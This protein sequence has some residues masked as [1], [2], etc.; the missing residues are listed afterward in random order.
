[1]D[2]DP[3]LPQVIVGTCGCLLPT[4]SKPVG[5]R[6]VATPTGD[7]RVA[8]YVCREHDK[9]KAPLEP[10]E[11]PEAPNKRSR[12]PRRVARAPAAS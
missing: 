10:T 4:D 11:A 5:F 8:L 12:R 7:K 2:Y 6:F 3:E 1:M 9:T